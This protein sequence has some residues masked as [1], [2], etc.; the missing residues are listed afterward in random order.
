MP[1]AELRRVDG[2]TDRP[3]FEVWTEPWGADPFKGPDGRDWHDFRAHE[4]G[5]TYSWRGGPEILRAL[6]EDVVRGRVSL[7]EVLAHERC[8]WWFDDQ[9]ECLVC[10]PGQDEAEKASEEDLCRRLLDSIRAG[11]MEVDAPDSSQSYYFFE[12]TNYVAD[13]AQALDL[14]GWARCEA[15]DGGGPGS[16][17]Q[18]WRI[19]LDP[20]R[21]LEELEAWLHDPA[22]A[23]SPG[24]VA[25]SVGLAD[26]TLEGDD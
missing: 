22:R 13:A 1:T 6:A 21:T 10:Q 5:A 4:D 12:W 9:I 2:K 11:T 15:G 17:F 8:S 19:S 7:S 25:L 3:T 20:G 26:A 23:P 16:G 24:D 14:P 18:G